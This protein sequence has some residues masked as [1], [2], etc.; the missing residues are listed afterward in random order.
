MNFHWLNLAGFIG[1]ICGAS[2]T[3]D[4]INVWP[5]DESVCATKRGMVV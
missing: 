3:V 4:S 2:E 5:K 1:H